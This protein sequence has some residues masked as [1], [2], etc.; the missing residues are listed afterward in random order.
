MVN[1]VK[2][3]TNRF[4]KLKEEMQEAIKKEFM[5]LIDENIISIK[6]NQYT[7]YFN[8][9]EECTFGMGD[10]EY[11]FSEAQMAL[12]TEK[13]KAQSDYDDNYFNIYS[14]VRMEGKNIKSFE[15]ISKFESMIDSLD[16]D[17]RENIFKTT[18]GDHVEII[19]DGKKFHI[20][21][22]DHE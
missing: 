17:L 4:K 12:L 11:E 5:R 13:E 16:A 3:I 19:F 10:F 21:D 6:W 1:T 14:L 2:E 15:K 20:N 18:F 22:Y 8:D 9:G 7:P